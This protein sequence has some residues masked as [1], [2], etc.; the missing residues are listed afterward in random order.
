MCCRR[1]RIA[2]WTPIVVLSKLSRLVAHLADGR[3]QDPR[4]FGQR[5]P[6]D[7][8]NGILGDQPPADR[9]ADGARPQIAGH[10]P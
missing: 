1:R 2:A 3:D 6:V 8:P 5:V 9:D 10:Q 4:P 7:M